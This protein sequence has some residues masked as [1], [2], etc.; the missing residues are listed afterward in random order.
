MASLRG[1]WGG[2]L[3]QVFASSLLMLLI[4]IPYIA[5]GEAARMVGPERLRA[6][7]L[8]RT[9]PKVTTSG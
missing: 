8:D 2:T 9:P 7:L 5:F 6:L 1:L 4:L 3:L